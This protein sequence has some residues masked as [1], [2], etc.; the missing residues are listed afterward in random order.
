MTTFWLLLTF[1]ALL[2]YGSVTFYVA[3]RGAA[4]IRVMLARLKNGDRER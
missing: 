1:A 2:L 4:D 3:V